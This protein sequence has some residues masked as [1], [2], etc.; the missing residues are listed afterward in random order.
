MTLQINSETN[1]YCLREPAHRYWQGGRCVYYFA[2]DLQ[3]L[4]GLLPQRTHENLNYITDANRRLTLSHAKNIQDYLHE[5]E[6]WLLGALLLGISPKAVEFEPYKDENGQ[7]NINF[8]ELRILAN[9]RNTMRIFDGQHRRHAIGDLLRE[10]DA[11]EN[12]AI[13]HRADLLRAS[14]SVA[15]YEEENMRS[16]R[17]MFTDAAQNKPIEAS[18]VTRFDR[19]NAFNRA[20]MYVVEE[21]RLFRGRIEMDRTTVTAGSSLLLAV[22]QLA[23]DLKALE[24]GI[25]GRV[26][27]ERNNEYIQNLDTLYLRCLDWADEF[28]PAAREEYEGLVK[29]EIDSG[30]IPALR[31][32][33]LALSATFIRILAGC[34]QQWLQRVSEDWKPLAQYVRN[35]NLTP[36]GGYGSLLVDAGAMAPGDSSPVGRRQEVQGAINYIVAEAQKSA[37]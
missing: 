28:L 35:A 15:L 4:D 34:Y 24:V 25:N 1:T 7:P 9:Q 11:A 33:S 36:G 16:L 21:S 13:G 19:R 17:Q 14:M 12:G 20:A 22:N 8:G 27:R 23:A 6:N 18:T 10:L 3:S 26:S 29:G 30:E 37:Q 2:L 31:R 5:H 32:K